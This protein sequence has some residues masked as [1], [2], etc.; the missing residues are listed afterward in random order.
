MPAM[1]AE[2]APASEAR[3]HTAPDS[4]PLDRRGLF[5]A[6]GAYALWGVFRLTAGKAE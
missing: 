3:M 1:A 5:A 2:C 4:P 6:A